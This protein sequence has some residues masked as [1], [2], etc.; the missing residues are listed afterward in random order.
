MAK[1]FSKNIWINLAGFQCAWWC[2]ILLGT[3]ALPILALLLF[4]HLRYHPAPGSEGLV[5]FACGLLGFAVDTLLTLLDVFRFETLLPPVWLLLLWFCFAATFR[6][7]LS[8]FQTRL[9]SAAL[10]GGIFGALTYLAAAKLGAFE[11]GVSQLL[12]FL[13]LALIWAALFP[14]LLSL[15][16]LPALQEVQDES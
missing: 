1:A 10:C 7:S 11:P 4:L 15:S 8:W 13:T 12:L 2:A 5:I 16:R 9:V 14:L 3:Q 6:Q